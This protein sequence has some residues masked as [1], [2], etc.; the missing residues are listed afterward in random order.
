[1]IYIKKGV[2]MKMKKKIL[3]LA[4]IVMLV[5]CPVECFAKEQ[6]VSILS[7]NMMD[8]VT[9]EFFLLNGYTEE[10]IYYEVYGETELSRSSEAVSVERTVI[11]ESIVIPSSTIAWEEQINGEMY[12]GNLSLVKYSFS[13][14]KTIAKYTGTLYKK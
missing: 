2:E 7:E 9:K 3:I 6:Q 13:S 14:G 10:G 8:K 5:Y 12:A 4:A 11:Y 1:M